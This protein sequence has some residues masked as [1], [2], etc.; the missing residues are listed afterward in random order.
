VSSNSRE[1]F[2]NK[3]FSK[4]ELVSI[5]LFIMLLIAV[6]NLEKI[7]KESEKLEEKY[8]EILSANDSLKELNEKLI[9]DNK[10]FKE[11]FD[12]E[13]RKKIDDEIDSAASESSEYSVTL[14]MTYD[15]GTHTW[16]RDSSPTAVR[17]TVNQMNTNTEPSATG[18]SAIAE[19]VIEEP[20][21]NQESFLAAAVI[22]CNR[23]GRIRNEMIP[24]EFIISVNENGKATDVYLSDD[25][26]ELRG[27]NL[28]LSRLIRLALMKSKYKP[29]LENENPVSMSFKLKRTYSQIFCT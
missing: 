8:T 2:F 27:S 4:A 13:Q 25:N 22:L 21:L 6:F 15:F 28:R 29:A 23:Q 7:L 24:L 1:N 5:L 16:K 19:E 11:I 26:P 18:V 20:I 12:S 14:P 3:I 10:T 9:A 17:D